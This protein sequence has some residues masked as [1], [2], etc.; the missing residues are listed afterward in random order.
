MEEDVGLSPVSSYSSSDRHDRLEMEHTSK[1]DALCNTFLLDS[2]T[3]SESHNTKRKF[4]KNIHNC[5]KLPATLLPIVGGVVQP[6]LIDYPL[7]LMTIFLLSALFSGLLTAIDPSGKRER[8][9]SA[10]ARYGELALHL[11]T[12]LA[13]SKRNRIAADVMITEYKLRLIE[14]NNSTPPL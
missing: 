13:T 14:L 11:Q 1:T 12:V 2:Q 8:H 5:L 9:D 6:H 7:I 4:W 3:Y 10:S